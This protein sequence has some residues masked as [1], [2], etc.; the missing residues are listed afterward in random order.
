MDEA[1]Q[2]FCPAR[3]G[4]EDEMD[5][6]IVSW[7]PEA[8]Q[9]L[10]MIGDPSVNTSVR[11]RAEKRALRA[12]SKQVLKAHVEPFVTESAAPV[13]EWTAAALARLTR[14]PELV[15]G[16][17]RRRAEANAQEAGA[18]DITM[19]ILE[20]AIE[21]GRA[22]MEDTMRGGGHPAAGNGGSKQ[23]G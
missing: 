17:L 23:D 1:T 8:E 13:I 9:A 12:G 21:E 10:A 20:T 6:D 19:E 2:R 14:V 4:D 7:T 15:R 5:T 16:S 18:S 11:L 22:V 3:G